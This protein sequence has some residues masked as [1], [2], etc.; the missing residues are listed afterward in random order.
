MS[1][2]ATLADISTKFD[3]LAAALA[4]NTKVNE[5]IAENQARLIAGQA[6][7]IEKIDAG[8]QVVGAKA[9]TAA[10]KKAAEKASVAET[11]ASVA[12]TKAA[13]KPPA[14][15]T[16]D[17]FTTAA[18]LEDYVRGWM[19]G[20]TDAAVRRTRVDLLKAIAANFGVDTKFAELLPYQKQTMF[21]IGRAKAG[22]KVDLK[23]DYDFDGDP[24]QGGEAVAAAAEGDF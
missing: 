10:E 6:A 23:A 1:L 8:K 5:K 7:A 9:P 19:N 22:L 24:T 16:T 11:K 2:E 4:A 13:E 14:V 15:V 21:F 20:S 3:G 18:E 17:R 12:E